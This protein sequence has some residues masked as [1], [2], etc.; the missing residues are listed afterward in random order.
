MP[1]STTAAAPPAPHAN[2]GP[3]R[4]VAELEGVYLSFGEQ[5]ILRGVNLLCGSRERLVVMG[6]SGSGK[7]TLLRLILGI[8]LP[9]KG[10]V[11]FEGREVGKM[12]RR[13]LNRMRGKIGM[14]YQNSALIS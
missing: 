14:V 7:S 9:Q 2:G 13:Q 6:R 5:E 8:L 11:R 12:K 4:P 10:R 3:S 1:L